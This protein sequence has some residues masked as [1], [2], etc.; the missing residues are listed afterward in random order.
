MK[1]ANKTRQTHEMGKR[2]NMSENASKQNC[3][4][5]QLLKGRYRNKEMNTS[6]YELILNMFKE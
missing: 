4:A 5:S 6:I 1:R 3:R 2:I